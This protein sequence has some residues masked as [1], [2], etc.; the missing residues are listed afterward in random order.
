ME[1]LSCNWHHTS[2]VEAGGRAHHM[3]DG[4]CERVD[5]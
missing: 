4:L 2:A 5:E 1:L 3:N